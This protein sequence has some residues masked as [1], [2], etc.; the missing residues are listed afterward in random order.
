MYSERVRKLSQ[1][2]EY[3][4]RDVYLICHNRNNDDAYIDGSMIS[5]LRKVIKQSKKHSSAALIIQTPGGEASTS[6]Y[7]GELFNEY[8]DSVDSYIVSDCYS[9][10]TFIAL[11]TDNI[12]M[13]HSGCLGPID[14]QIMRSVSKNNLEE[15]WYPNLTGKI[16]ALEKAN[17]S[18]LITDTMRET[19]SKSPAILAE[20]FQQKF[21][22]EKLMGENVRK[23]CID[24]SK[25]EEIWNYL[26]SINFSHGN[27]LT[28][29]KL[30]KTGL[31]VKLMSE[32]EERLIDRIVGDTEH[33]FGE[34]SEKNVLSYFFD[35]ENT[36]VID[37]KKIKFGKDKDDTTLEVKTSKM[38]E[39]LG[40]IET[41]TTGF[42]QTVETIVMSTENIPNSIIPLSIGWQEEMDDSSISDEEKE[43]LGKIVE[44]FA[45][46]N[47]CDE[48][49][50]ELEISGAMVKTYNNLYNNA[51]SE[52]KNMGYEL[53]DLPK[54][55][56]FK[57]IV[58][59]IINDSNVDFDNEVLQK[60]F[61]KFLK[62]NDIC[63][64]DIDSAEKIDLIEMF[65]N[66]KMKEMIDDS[67][68]KISQEDF[69]NLPRVDQIDLVYDYI[70]DNE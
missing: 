33:E 68:L 67:N 29:K 45:E 10:G 59:Y 64:Y 2:E 8:Y 1:L 25:Y 48:D 13:S 32:E 43:K 52:I 24:N 16:E 28:Y 6:Y 30:V 14:V 12:Y 44:F 3:L 69:D 5:V 39:V 15:V 22:F 55:K 49:L 47:M 42:V 26:A 70:I 46:Q 23:H 19:F 63:Y 21:T 66:E 62:K 53:E 35:G 51:L 41:S 7:V 65:F 31:D 11:S 40:F 9:G 61:L 57:I 27:S 37:S 54:T 4:D 58:E 56:L 34:L 18:E 60:S 38:I 36:S 20:Y 50:D 17:E